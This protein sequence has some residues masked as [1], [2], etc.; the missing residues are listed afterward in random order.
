MFQKSFVNCSWWCCWF[1]NYIDNNVIFVN[2][3]DDDINA[4]KDNNNENFTLRNVPFSD[5]TKVINDNND[6]NNNINNVI[7]N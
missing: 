6:S 3:I 4:F 1:N 5:K 7:V 2:N